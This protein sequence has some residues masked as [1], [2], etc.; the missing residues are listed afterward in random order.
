MTLLKTLII[1][2]VCVFAAGQ[3]HWV[4]WKIVDESINEEVIIIRTLLYFV[5][6]AES[7]FFTGMEQSRGLSEKGKL[8]AGKVKDVLLNEHI[9]VLISSPYERA[10]L[11][12]KDLAI[13]LNMDIRLEEGLRERQLTG[14]GHEITKEQFFESKRRVY[15][16]RNYS[17]PGGESSKQAQERAI[18]IL[19]KILEEFKG[20]R[21]AIGT[22]GDIMTLMMNY[23]DPTYDFAFW[24]STTMPDIYKLEFEENKLKHVTRLWN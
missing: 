16:D 22:H 9:D 6:H 19:N 4:F 1:F 20:K 10:I 23:F 3:W 5:R 8:D 13:E 2:P 12:I 18:S 14:K 15:E 21:I 24:K 7:P 11:T 17:F